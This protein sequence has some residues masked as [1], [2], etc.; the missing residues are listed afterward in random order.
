MVDDRD[1]SWLGARR[2]APVVLTADTLVWRLRK[3]GR[4][5]CLHARP[6]PLGI[7]IRSSVD[8]A[9]VW[10]QVVRTGV[11]VGA[12]SD[13]HLHAWVARGWILDAETPTA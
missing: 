13:E 5:A 1:W 2:P 8:G 12:V 7:E 10:S 9:F 3:A 4:V 11:D 6:H